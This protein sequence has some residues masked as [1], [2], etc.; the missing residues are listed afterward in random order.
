MTDAL[1]NHNAMELSFPR[2]IR[3]VDLIAGP[4]E[5]WY[6]QAGEST[7]RFH[8]RCGEP[9]ISFVEPMAVSMLGAWASHQRNQGHEVIVDDTLKSPASF[10]SGLLSAIAGRDG[11][12]PSPN[13]RF[14]R[15]T[16]ERQAMELLDP[17]VEKMNLPKA[18]ERVAVH[19]LS[20]LADNVFH[21]ASAGRQGAFCSIAYDPSTSRVRLAVA[22]CGQGIS[23]SIG[24]SYDGEL[25]DEASVLLAL[26]PEF[27]GKS[28]RP[29][30]NRGVG[31]YVVRRLALA[32][33]GAFCALT[34]E[35]SV[36]ASARSPSDFIPRISRSKQRWK[37]TAIAVTFTADGADFDGPIAAIRDEIEGRG[38]KYSDIH[39]FKKSEPTIGWTHV[40]IGCDN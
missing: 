5:D 26:E 31:L 40:K 8:L 36:Q 13:H 32:A 6:W 12:P 27:S 28:A 25:D 2:K 22:D 30:V 15:L 19:C 24:P 4:S 14:A 39:F 17:L 35:L 9:P 29:E 11:G 7:H 1:S 16:S 34:E 38:P 37:G 21:H 20:D 23:A 18:A 33:S 10:N 3:I